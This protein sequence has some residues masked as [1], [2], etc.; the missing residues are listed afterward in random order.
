MAIPIVILILLIV[1]RPSFIQEES[2]DKKGTITSRLSFKKAIQYWL[3][4]S[5]VLVVTVAVYNYKKGN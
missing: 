5:T 1:F 4:L 2:V 3:V